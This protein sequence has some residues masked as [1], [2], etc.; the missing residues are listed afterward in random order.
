MF[1]IGVASEERASDPK[2]A[3]CAVELD[4]RGGTYKPDPNQRNG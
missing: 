1:D 4:E 3:A 2:R